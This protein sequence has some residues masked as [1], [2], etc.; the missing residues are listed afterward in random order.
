V[1]T[2]DEHLKA[3]NT[4]FQAIDDNSLRLKHSNKVTPP[5]YWLKRGVRFSQTGRNHSDT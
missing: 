3:I 5:K 4:I 1:H 2:K